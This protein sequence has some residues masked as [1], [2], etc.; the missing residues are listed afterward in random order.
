MRPATEGTDIIS[1][2]GARDA[3]IR[4]ESDEDGTTITI[5]VFNSSVQDPNLA[6]V[7][8]ERFDASPSGAAEATEF[9]RSWGFAQEI[10]W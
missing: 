1:M 10:L 8:S 3:H 6:H 7:E 4:L 2:N 5:D 9:L